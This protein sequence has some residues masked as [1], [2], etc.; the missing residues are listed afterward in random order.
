MKFWSFFGEIRDKN[1]FVIRN[2]LF[3]LDDETFKKLYPNIKT[4]KDIDFGE[5]YGVMRYDLDFDKLDIVLR[6]EVNVGDD[7]IFRIL[8]FHV[9]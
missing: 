3:K 1:G 4:I 5:E 6:N 7:E 9:E 8:Y 2:F